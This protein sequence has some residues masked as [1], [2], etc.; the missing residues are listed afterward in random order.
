M[1][2]RGPDISPRALGV[3]TT[4]SLASDVSQPCIAQDI[5]P[6]RLCLMHLPDSSS[7]AQDPLFQLPPYWAETGIEHELPQLLVGS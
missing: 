6:L 4:L 2:T 5:C 7:E 1:E 3:R